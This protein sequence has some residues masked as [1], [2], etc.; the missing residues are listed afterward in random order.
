MASKREGL[1]IGIDL[2]PRTLTS[3]CGSRIELRSLPTIRQKVA[4]CAKIFVGD[5]GTTRDIS[6]K[7]T[8]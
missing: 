5:S 4:A 8:L 7:I 3:V 6:M 2:E 1:A